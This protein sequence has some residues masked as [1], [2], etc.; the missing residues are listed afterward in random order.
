MMHI[1]KAFAF[2]PRVERMPN[3]RKTSEHVTKIERIM[4]T[5]IIHVRPATIFVNS[6]LNFT[7]RGIT[8]W[9]AL[10]RHPVVRDR[11]RQDLSKV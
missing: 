1:G 7:M 3:R 10:T 2:A 11:I 6:S 9:E 4:R 8:V 5:M